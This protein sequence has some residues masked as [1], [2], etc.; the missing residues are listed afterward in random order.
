MLLLFWGLTIVVVIISSGNNIFFGRMYYI[1]ILSTIHFP[2]ITSKFLIF[3]MFVID[4][5]TKVHVQF[6]GMFMMHLSFLFH[7]SS[8]SCSLVVFVSKLKAKEH[9]CMAVMIII[10][11]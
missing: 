7:M 9:F 6:V 8:S 5:Q 1:L 2:D 4:L 3:I 10:V 11:L